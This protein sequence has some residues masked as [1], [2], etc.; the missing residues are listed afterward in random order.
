[1][2]VKSTT[3]LHTD[4]VRLHT[5]HDAESATWL[6]VAQGSDDAVVTHVPKRT[7]AHGRACHVRQAWRGAPSCHRGAPQVQKP[8][9]AQEEQVYQPHACSIAAESARPVVRTA[10]RVPSSA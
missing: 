3:D 10:E 9:R 5:V 2:T 1:M 4:G 6:C 7:D 8:P